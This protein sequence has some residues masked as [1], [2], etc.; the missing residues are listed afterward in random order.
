M[1]HPSKRCDTCQFWDTDD[2]WSG[3]NSERHPDDWI[4]NCHR[5][6]PPA[7]LGDFEYE[8]LHLLAMIAWDH[9]DEA[10]KEKAFKDW[11]ESMLVSSSWPGTHGRDWCGEWKPK[12][13][14]I[15]PPD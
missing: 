6:A 7:S 1:G 8:L 2:Q 9:A 13:A 15:L 14:E 3:I 10:E 11:E 12:A 5:N 4:G